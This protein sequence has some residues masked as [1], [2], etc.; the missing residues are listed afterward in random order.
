VHR[1]YISAIELGKVRL[2]LL[3]SMRLA[4]ALGLPLSKLIADAETHMS[5]AGR[6]RSKRIL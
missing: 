4:D 5:L 3:V 1:T 2:G 6:D